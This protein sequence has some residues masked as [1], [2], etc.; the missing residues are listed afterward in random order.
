M[1]E[2]FNCGADAD[3]LKREYEQALYKH[4]PE[5]SYTMISYVLERLD[6]NGRTG[7]DMS[8]GD[9]TA[10]HAARIIRDLVKERNRMREGN[11]TVDEIHNFCHNLHGTVSAAEFANG[12]A[13][14][15]RKFYGYAPDRDALE[16]LK[17]LV[18]NAAQEFGF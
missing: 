18:R 2:N 3:K 15:Q 12:C 1:T 7:L 17:A 6:E 5:E 14:E 8:P 9:P 4:P 13:A 11:F 16:R 10:L